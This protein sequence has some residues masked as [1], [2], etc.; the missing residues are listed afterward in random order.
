MLCPRGSLHDQIV[1]QWPYVRTYTLSNGHLFLSLMAD[2]GIYE[3]EPLSVVASGAR[4]VS[5]TASY[6]ERIALPAN[7]VLEVSLE[8]VAPRGAPTGLIARVRNEQPGNPPIPF[9][10][11]YD[12]GRIN[13]N[14]SYVVRGRILVDE[15]EWFATQQ[16]YPILTG[17]RGSDVQILLRR[18]VTTGV[19]G[20]VPGATLASLENT[21]WRLTTLGNT[22]VRAPR[23]R[24]PNFTLH[25]A[26]RTVTGSG[27]CNSMSGT[28]QVRGDRITFGR[29]TTTMMA[30]VAG[31]DSERAYLTALAQATR[32]RIT[33]QHL[34]L[35]D[36]RGVKVAG[37]DAVYM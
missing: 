12:P 24:E 26:G 8:E 22:P 23:Q 17:G 34:E 29:F 33:G 14:R 11:S 10:I 9:M 35:F 4:S 1:R 3:L 16:A 37:F 18:T 28:Y 25:R 36:S 6:R 7:A 13:P 20:R 15:Q 2:G 32:W 19:S 5:G 27:G 31:M 30:C 21:Y